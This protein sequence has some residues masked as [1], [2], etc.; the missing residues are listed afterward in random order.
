[1]RK[2]LP[3]C[4]VLFSALTLTAAASP[5]DGEVRFNICDSEG[6]PLP[7]ASFGVSRDLAPDVHGLGQDGTI[8]FP[9]A[10]VAGTLVSAWA[11]GF[12]TAT[13]SLSDDPEEGYELRL[14]P[15][16]SIRGRVT[17]T[18]GEPVPGGVRVA[19]IDFRSTAPSDRDLV[20]RTGLPSGFSSPVS[21]DGSFHIDGLVEG[22]PYRVTAFGAGVHS[23]YSKTTGRVM[24]PNEDLHLTLRY[25][26]GV[27]IE[28][29][30]APAGMD[31][32]LG[33]LRQPPQRGT[34]SQALTHQVRFEE[35]YALPARD[36]SLRL[37]GLTD[38]LES[39]WKHLPRRSYFS[40]KSR[41]LTIKSVHVS[42]DVPFAAPVSAEAPTGPVATT[43]DLVVLTLPSP[44]FPEGWSADSMG[45]VRVAITAP[46]LAE[47][48]MEE[49]LDARLVLRPHG[50]HGVDRF[51]LAMDWDPSGA[52]VADAVPPGRY[53]AW[54]SSPPAGWIVP[55]WNSDGW[56]LHVES[57]STSIVDATSEPL[58]A[59]E[60]T[61]VDPGGVPFTGALAIDLTRGTG[62]PGSGWTCLAPRTPEFAAGRHVI[63]LVHPSVLRTG[64]S[65]AAHMHFVFLERYEGWQPTPIPLTAGQ[66]SQVTVETIP[67]PMLQPDGT[68]APN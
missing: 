5:G 51:A 25:L 33:A 4:Q 31:E 3:V 43:E 16:T 27:Q 54:L 53:D 67:W 37:A 13:V 38:P 62:A 44:S 64:E 20:R 66:V 14:A 40:A 34:Y 17:M 29:A 2:L 63:P 35:E 32:F 24:A 7:Q 21:P 15:A 22:V 36:W 6:R 55:A 49:R 28:H 52:L 48:A 42:W 46:W 65:L 41:D 45:S 60:F 30:D 68:V 11:D 26:S 9:E 58:S 61:V 19:A 50:N 23:P 59:V 47:P 10:D 8:A 18:D 1:M 12:A 56:T 39:H 57:G